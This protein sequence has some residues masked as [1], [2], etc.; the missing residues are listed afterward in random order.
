MVDKYFSCLHEATGKQRQPWLLSFGSVL[1][2]GELGLQ[3][4]V[5][6]AVFLAKSDSDCSCGATCSVCRVA[7]E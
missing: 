7:L 1:C 3:A 4:V 6:R 2:G 5:S